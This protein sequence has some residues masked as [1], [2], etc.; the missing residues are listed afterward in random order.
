MEQ[1]EPIE[2][3][4]VPSAGQREPGLA[5]EGLSDQDLPGDQYELP[6]EEEDG[7]EKSE[8]QVAQAFGFVGLAALRPKIWNFR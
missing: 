6:G 4:P 1:I 5:P 8:T 2:T 3:I 7:E